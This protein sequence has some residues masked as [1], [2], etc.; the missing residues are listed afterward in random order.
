MVYIPAAIWAMK[1][2]WA[3]PLKAIGEGFYAPRFPGG[4]TPELV[5]LIMANIGTT[6]TPWQIF[7]Q[8]SAVVDKGMDI[9]DH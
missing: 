3:P 7:F 8:Q 5:M 6:I 1:T 9:R 4:L 2:N